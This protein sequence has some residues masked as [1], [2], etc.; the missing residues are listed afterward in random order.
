MSQKEIGTKL[1][2]TWATVTVL[3]DGLEK[4]GLVVR[5]TSERDRRSTNVTLTPA[6]EEACTRI[7][8]AMAK[9]SALLCEGFTEEEKQALTG[10]LLRFWHN[11]RAFD[12]EKDL[13]PDPAAAPSQKNS[14]RK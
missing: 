14:G 7:V 10:L 11:A 1:M 4:D 8:P 13:G 5:A 2:V 9:M 3:V 12:P 6:G